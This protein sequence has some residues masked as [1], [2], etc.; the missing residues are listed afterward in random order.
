MSEP[1]STPANSTTRSGHAFGFLIPVVLF[2]LALLILTD[3][4]KFTPPVGEVEQVPEWATTLTPV[5]QPKLVP[6]T[7]IESYTYRC[8]DCHELMEEAEEAERPLSQHGEIVLEH[9]INDRCFNCHNNENRDTFAGNGGQPIPFDQPQLLCAKCH[10]PVYRD[11]LHGVH[12]RTNGYWNTKLGSMTRLKCIE[13]HDP[14]TPPFK[15]L[16]PAPPPETLRMGDQ[17]IPPVRELELENPLLIYRQMTAEGIRTA[18]PSA[19]AS[20]PSPGGADE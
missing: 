9:G 3:L 1:E 8:T 11:W 2:A 19:P 10:G 16:R 17:H 4:G 5:R 6:E 7:T 20:Q 13:C 14:H 18:P 12:G 15:P